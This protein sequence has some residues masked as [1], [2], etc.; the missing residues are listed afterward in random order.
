MATLP[1][2][3]SEV[4]PKGGAR[5]AFSSAFKRTFLSSLRSRAKASADAS[6][7]M[8]SKSTAQVV[9]QQSVENNKLIE[10]S[11]AITRDQNDLLKSILSS[12]NNFQI[13]DLGGG[14]GDFNP[15]PSRRFFDEKENRRSNQE[16]EEVNR[17]K[18]QQ[19]AEEETRKR[20][21]EEASTKREHS[22]KKQPPSL[23]TEANRIRS[24]GEV[25]DA[26][27]RDVKS[28][29]K[30][31]AQRIRDIVASHEKGEISRGEARG[32][33]RDIANPPA[34]PVAKSPLTATV[35]DR[36]KTSS[37][38]GG[39]TEKIKQVAKKIVQKKVTSIIAK[40]IPFAG[41]LYALGEAGYQ[42][43][44]GS[45]AQAATTIGSGI[46][47]T[48]APFASPAGAVALNNIAMTL[49]I[50]GMAL[51]LSEEL[52]NQAQGTE[53]I[54]RDAINQILREE[55]I[56]QLTAAQ[57]DLPGMPAAVGDIP[58]PLSPQASKLSEQ[59]AV[60][61][62]MSYGKSPD[63]KYAQ[64]W[65]SVWRLGR[66]PASAVSNSTKGAA[67]NQTSTINQAAMDSK[68]DQ[69]AVNLIRTQSSPSAG[70]V[71]QPETDDAD[72][73]PIGSLLRGLTTTGNRRFKDR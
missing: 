48:A 70:T 32:L 34:E 6:N 38:S 24:G 50:A 72:D 45:Y 49:D 69:P 31:K 37:E 7:D 68:K 21:A 18:K 29:G 61:L 62:L 9:A 25:S 23:N 36:I 19:N 33:L 39:I 56:N 44:A 41:L 46:A 66:D 11:I 35:A 71:N 59:D 4:K 73:I 13:P 47:S 17:Q 64:D 54:S 28:E 51:Q 10:K 26:E 65:L 20:Q 40:K 27:A 1:K 60:A 15:G 57:D 12:L 67:L 58:D 8:V 63:T 55:L 30:G 42:T 16:E 53:P 5:A 14:L 43:Y 22:K 52:S 3:S 2:V